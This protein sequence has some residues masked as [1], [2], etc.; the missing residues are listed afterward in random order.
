MNTH[1]PIRNTILTFLLFSLSFTQIINVQGKILTQ[2]NEPISGVNIYTGDVG[3]SS[4]S[5]GSFS[6]NVDANARVTFSHIGHTEI[7]MFDL[8]NNGYIK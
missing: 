2:N 7:N 5:D 4:Q 8:K 1:Y 6:L 3:T